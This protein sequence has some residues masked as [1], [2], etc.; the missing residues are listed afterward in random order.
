MGLGPMGGR[1]GM[2]SCSLPAPVDVAGCGLLRPA[3][4]VGRL[5][6]ACQLGRVFTLWRLDLAAARDGGVHIATCFMLVV[7]CSLG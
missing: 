1:T 2:V 5:A 4:S 6:G 3:G 7:S